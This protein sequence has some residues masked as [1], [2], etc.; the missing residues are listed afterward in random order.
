VGVSRFISETHLQKA[1]TARANGNWQK[2]IDEIELAENDYYNIDPMCTPLKWYSGSAQY[3]L[4]NQELAFAD[5]Y[6][7]YQINPNHVHVLNN[8]AT[9]YEI[10]GDHENAIV[11]YQKAILISP[12]FEEAVSNLCATYFNAGKK[13]EAF[14]EFQNLTIDTANVK[15]KQMLNLILCQ[16]IIRLSDSISCDPLKNMVK[17]I[18]NTPEWYK[19]IY[20]KA[21][22]KNINFKGQVIEDAIYTMDSIEKKINFAYISSIQKKYTIKKSY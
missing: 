14:K 20:L 18:S 21:K 1:Y 15:Y 5:F 9:S 10:K 13:Q 17:A 22:F 3:N 19:Q 2:T 16:E 11:Y 4:G 8:L 6:K 12:L 7:A